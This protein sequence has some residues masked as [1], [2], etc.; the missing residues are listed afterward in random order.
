MN[1]SNWVLVNEWHRVLPLAILRASIYRQWIC[2]L[3]EIMAGNCSLIFCSVY[4]CPLCHLEGL[5]DSDEVTSSLL[6]H[7]ASSSSYFK[8]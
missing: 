7:V 1:G 5:D 8:L 6:C 4:M 3:R 2:P